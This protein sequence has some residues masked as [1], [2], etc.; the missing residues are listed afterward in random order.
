M[1]NYMTKRCSFLFFLVTWKQSKNTVHSKKKS[2][3]H[4]FRMGLAQNLRDAEVGV[5]DTFT[6]VEI[7]ANDLP[8][9]AC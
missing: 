7:P 2:H 1:K 6:A 4:I 3:E 9:R 8:P 5:A